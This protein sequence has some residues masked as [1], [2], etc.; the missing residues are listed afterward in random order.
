MLHYFADTIEA[1]IVNE[2]CVTLGYAQTL[3]K[4]HLFLTSKKSSVYVN[5]FTDTHKTS[6]YTDKRNVD[7]AI[8][9][10]KNSRKI[11]Y[12]LFSKNAC[13]SNPRFTLREQ[14]QEPVRSHPGRCGSTSSHSPTDYRER[15]PRLTA[16]KFLNSF[17]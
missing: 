4:A 5:S 6:Q 13:N 2:F 16:N 10:L 17:A 11:R 8:N 3:D 14:T 1:D 15:G 12:S 7:S 9:E